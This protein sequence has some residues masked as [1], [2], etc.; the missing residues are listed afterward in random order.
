MKCFS[1]VLF[2][3]AYCIWC[4]GKGQGSFFTYRRLFPGRTSGRALTCQGRS[5]VG[6]L[7]FIP[8]WEDPLEEGMATHSSILAGESPWT[9]ELGRLQSVWSNLAC[10]LL[11]QHHLLKIL[12]FSSIIFFRKYLV[13]FSNETIWV[14]MFLCGKVF[15]LQ[16][17]LT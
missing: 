15:K 2:L 7:G 12:H 17:Q 1:C 9:K 14:W 8:G 11:F 16:I 3:A 6:D 10:T 5:A 4:W 13:E